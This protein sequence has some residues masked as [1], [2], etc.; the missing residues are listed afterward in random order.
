MSNL[1][2]RISK[3]DQEW[4]DNMVPV[5]KKIFAAIA[6]RLDTAPM[7]V[8]SNV[9]ASGQEWAN[10]IV[11]IALEEML[12]ADMRKDDAK[13][14]YQMLIQ[15]VVAVMDRVENSIAMN[16]EN[17]LTKVFKAENERSITM[18]QVHSVLMGFDMEPET[19]VEEKPKGL[20]AFIRSLWTS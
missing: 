11:R 6:E 16:Y 12:A 3:E 17:A 1:Q 9:V 14:L 13:L 7:S 5:A 4:N 18:K 10:P 20:M 15:P 19:P 8:V 2:E